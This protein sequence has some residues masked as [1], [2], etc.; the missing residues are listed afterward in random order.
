[1]S[2]SFVV[3]ADH[4]ADACEVVDG[5]LSLEEM[6]TGPNLKQSDFFFDNEAVVFTSSVSKSFEKK[7]GSQGMI[8]APQSF[9]LRGFYECGDLGHV[10]KYCPYFCKGSRKQGGQTIILVSIATPS[11]EPAQGGAHPG[12]DC[13]RDGAQC[14]RG[15]GRFYL[16]SGR[17]EVFASDSVVTWIVYVF[18]RD[19]SV[20]FD[21]GSTYSYVS[22][23]FACFLDMPR[24]FFDAL[25]DVST[26][27]RASI[28]VGRVYRSCVVTLCCFEMR[29][30][31]L[32]LDMV[33]I[34]VIFS[35]DCLS[36]YHSIFDCHSKSVK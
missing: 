13:P 20:L 33:D 17:T 21:L 14:S 3:A 24:D 34:D 26:P 1:M 16:F 12:R 22:S 25:V 28:V 18:H 2:H 29:S 4:V 19:A 9:L 23:Y 32:L 11:S 15:Q 5:G 36:L 31:L 7:E 27:V 30:D 6:F 35:M 10:R 8:Q